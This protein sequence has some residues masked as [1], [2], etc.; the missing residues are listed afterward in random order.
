MTWW[1][2]LVLVLA[3]LALYAV[4]GL[5]LWRRAKVLLGELRVLSEL[6]ERLAAVTGTE[7]PA[8]VVPAYLA[9]PAEVAEA[10]HRRQANLRARRER[11]A[12][13]AAQAMTR[14]RRVGLR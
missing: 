4:V 1:L 10:G 9:P 2:W 6:S 13:R 14:W 11:R 3:A 12:D 8:A 5:G 7:P